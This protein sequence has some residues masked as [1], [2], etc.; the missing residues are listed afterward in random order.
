MR[1]GRGD[2]VQIGRLL[3]M[4]KLFRQ[5]PKRRLRICPFINSSPTRL[6]TI[7]NHGVS[8]TR[9][10]H[11]KALQESLLDAVTRSG[12]GAE[13]E[14]TPRK[15]LPG[16]EDFAR[17][18]PSQ[19]TKR[20]LDATA[21]IE[22][23][24]TKR[25]RL[26]RTDTQRSGITDEN[27]E[28]AIKTE[29][30]QPKPKSPKRPYASFLKDFIDP[31]EDPRPE[32]SHTFVFEWL[33]S[34]ESDRGPRCRSD[35]YFHGSD[36]D[37]VPRQLAKSAPEMG[38]TQVVDGFVVP[39]TPVSGRSASRNTDAGS[40]APS[41]SSGRSSVRLVENPLYRSMNLAANNVYM[42]PPYEDFPKHIADLVMGISKKRDS[43]EPTLDE[44]RQNPD[45]AAL[46]W[47]GAGESQV[48]QH[49][50]ST[51]FPFFSITESLQRSDKQP[52]TKHAVPTT[53]SKLRLSNPIPDMLYGYNRQAA[54][55][56]QQAQLISI[57]AA[58]VANR[59]DLLYPFFAIEFKGDG[60]S[61]VGSL[62]VATN[63]CLG[64]STSCVNIAER[65]NNQLDQCR[66]NEAHSINSAA[67]SIAMNGTEAR[68]YVSWKHD[69]HRYYMKS[70]ESFL[71]QRP[72]HYLEFRKYVLNIINWGKNKRLAEIRNSLDI[73]LE[74][75]RKKASEAAKSRQPPSDG[76]GTSKRRRSSLES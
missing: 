29:L 19:S 16:N 60:P 64:D 20:R 46:Q 72:E 75:T 2:K 49:F 3:C 22:L 35:S 56:Q 58:N 13:L 6:S 52:I 1:P 21:G 63:Q 71:L 66:S 51:I 27:A 18:A 57:G 69:K 43:P 26:C 50:R 38:H 67:F 11:M 62:W 34:V 12:I 41:N 23:V 59:Q 33:K 45:L 5:Q 30:Q 73:L 47:S 76:S 53:G 65:L 28:Q 17:G 32:S 54:F 44:V 31:I 24:P 55:P 4:M 37:P 36:D 61:G 8:K 74:E 68:L 15:Q 40:D 14:K 10:P 7:M 48:E 25:A 70:V 39:P 42:R 9:R